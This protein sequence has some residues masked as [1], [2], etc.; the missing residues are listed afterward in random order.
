MRRY[1]F[2]LKSEPDAV[3]SDLTRNNRQHLPNT[4]P[5][6][7]RRKLITNRKLFLFFK[8]HFTGIS[9]FHTLTYSVR[10]IGVDRGPSLCTSPFRGVF[11]VIAT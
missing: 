5:E 1:L 7:Y 8:N 10:F 3:A 6:L 11:K 4:V 2:G 9:F